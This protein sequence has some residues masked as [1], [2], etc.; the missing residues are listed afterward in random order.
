MDRIILFIKE[1][2]RLLLGAAV[3][4]FL[5]VLVITLL[6]NRKTPQVSVNGETFKVEVADNDTEKQIGLSEKEDLKENE[7]MIFVFENPGMYS[8]WM[9][10]M[11][12][13]IDIVYIN[14]DKV[15]TV[16]PNAQPPVS[17]ND[18]LPIY[19]PES[20]SDRILEIKA[21]LA[22]KHNIQK[23]STVKIENL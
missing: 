19:Q 2:I 22:S 20:V 23:G 12:F 18:E 5:I 13:P 8:F 9:K 16:I 11:N 3:V 15:T 21:G 1:N 7:G 4:I 6:L 10:E 17:E 14:G